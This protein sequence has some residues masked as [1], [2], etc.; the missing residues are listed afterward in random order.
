[1]NSPTKIN[2]A[3]YLTLPLMATMQI[4][5]AQNVTP[6]VAGIAPNY[7]YKINVQT[8]GIPDTLLIDAPDSYSSR[9][10]VKISVKNK[11][12]SFHRPGDAQD[13][14][15]PTPNY[16]TTRGDLQ[17]PLKV[18]INHVPF[19]FFAPV[20]PLH[21][22][23]CIVDF[24]DSGALGL[25]EPSLWFDRIYL[26]WFQNCN[27]GGFVDIRPLVNSHF[28]VGY[29]DPNVLP[30]PSH[31]QAYPSIIEDDGECNFVDV[32]TEPRTYMTTHT[33]TE[34]MWLRARGVLD[35]W[36]TFA[37]NQVRI[38]GNNAVRICYRKDQEVDLSWLT[39]GVEQGTIPGVWL[40]WSKLDPGTW[41]LSN[42]VW[43]VTDVKITGADH[44]AGPFSLDDFHF[45]ID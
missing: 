1:M 30:C 10:P 18:N 5:H 15:V 24:N 29:E 2:Y 20:V 14:I 12:L 36:T 42:Y 27:G 6:G 26:P 17:K 8:P 38:A 11:M 23:E 43:N 25:S 19:E 31:D 40:C 35:Q 45:V 39:S 9:S 28:H 13:T 16:G 33:P 3:F 44:S 32:P 21:A 41:D 37:L 34:Y 7:V 22:A 4:V